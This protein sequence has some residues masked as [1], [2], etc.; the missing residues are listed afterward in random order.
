MSSYGVVVA[1]GRGAG[2]IKGRVLE[3]PHEFARLAARNR[4]RAG[5]HGRERAFVVDGTIA[6]EP[7]DRRRA[8]RRQEPNRLIA[9][10][11]NHL[12]TIPW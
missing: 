10:R 12:V 5:C 3:E 8:G 1:V 7:L 11:V 9:A 4:R 2:G 6:H